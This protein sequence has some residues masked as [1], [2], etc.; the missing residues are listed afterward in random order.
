M[1]QFTAVAAVAVASVAGFGVSLE[2]GKAISN[3]Y[4]I[5]KNWLLHRK[6]FP[7]SQMNH[8]SVDSTL[9]NHVTWPDHFVSSRSFSL[10]LWFASHPPTRTQ[11]FSSFS[12]FSP[13]KRSQ[14]LVL[15]LFPSIL[16]LHHRKYEQSQTQITLDY[17]LQWFIAWRNGFIL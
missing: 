9:Y 11:L 12:H 7:I 1:L 5:L 17:I 4:Y 10:V 14:A 3:S 13:H 2:S 15:V 8:N 16:L 6:Q